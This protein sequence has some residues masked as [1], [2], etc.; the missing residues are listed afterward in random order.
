MPLET[1]AFV[2]AVLVDDPLEQ[3]KVAAHYARHLAARVAPLPRRP[4]LAHE[5]RLRVGYL[6]ADFHQHATSQL[7]VQM[8]EAHD[9]AR[10]EVTLFSAGPDDGT[11][12]RQRM[13]E[14]A[15][16]ILSDRNRSIEE[17]GDLLH[18]AWLIKRRLSD[19]VTTSEIDEIYERARKAGALGGKLLGAG[20]GGFLLLFA[21]P[22]DQPRIREDL[23]HLIHAPVN[24]DESGSRVVLYQPNG[25]N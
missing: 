7:A 18:Q 9:R 10:F 6:S 22:E 13:V 15:V 11:P 2:H 24:F 21:R 5:G 23:K 17:F 8:F 1:G 25:L 20:G 14:E 4:V 3:R 16:R 19:K 12:L